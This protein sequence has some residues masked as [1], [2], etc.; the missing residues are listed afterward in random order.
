MTPN[1][2]W[3]SFW[4]TGS[5]GGAIDL[6]A[7]D[8]VAATLRHHWAA[9]LDWLARCQ[10]VVDVGSGPAILARLLYR[11]DAPRI[12]PVQWFCFD[13][14]DLPEVKELPEGIQLRGGVDFAREPPEGDGVDAVLGNFGLE[15]VQ[16]ES[17]APACAR[18]LRPAG[19]LHG[20]M[21]VANSVIDRVSAEAAAD[22][23]WAID[24]VGLHRVTAP[25]LQAMAT[26]PEDPIER[27]MHGVEERDAYNAAV[28]RLKQRMETR[29]AY[30]AALL[31]MLNATR[32]LM[33]MVQAGD[34]PHALQALHA[35]DAAMVAE[36]G[37]LHDMRRSALG[38]GDVQSLVKALTAAGL[39]DVR[40]ESLGCAIG[41]VALAFSARRP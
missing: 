33:T 39:V 21:H 29:G 14:A 31:E 32:Q 16:R 1:Q 9:Q 38:H 15:Y 4:H 12:A 18:W 30:S 2:A 5:G 23:A 24:D 19:R 41:P 10:R 11:L 3:A 7:D 17:L 26:L 20:V 40:V 27:M 13:L 36:V 25:L 34:L 37:R 22:I 8:P 6:D 28:N 35:R